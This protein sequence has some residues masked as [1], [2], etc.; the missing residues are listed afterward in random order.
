MKL[1]KEYSTFNLYEDTEGVYVIVSDNLIDLGFLFLRL[2]EF[3]ENPKYKNVYFDLVDFIHDYCKTN[4]SKSFS[5]CT[6]WG[7]YNVPDFIFTNIFGKTFIRNTFDDLMY[8]VYNT[9]QKRIGN[10]KWCCIGILKDD[11]ETLMHVKCRLLL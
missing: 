9:I 3:Y 4:K 5:Y 10:K 1:I 7:G 11:E 6:D 2:Q 8:D